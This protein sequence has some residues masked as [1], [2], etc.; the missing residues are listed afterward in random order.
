MKN[1]RLCNAIVPPASS[2]LAVFAILR[3]FE[4]KIYA[5]FFLQTSGFYRIFNPS[6]ASIETQNA[7]S[8]PTT[9]I[10]RRCNSV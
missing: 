2:A 9:E 5:G 3:S 7:E 4:T 6:H 10:S 8:E 1:R